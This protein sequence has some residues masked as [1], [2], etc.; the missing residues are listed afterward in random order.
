[1]SQ[2]RKHVSLML[3]VVAALGLDAA[4]VVHGQQRVDPVVSKS[5]VALKQAFADAARAR[6]D[7]RQ[8]VTRAE[9]YADRAR[10][11]ASGQAREV[12]DAARQLGVGLHEFYFHP[13]SVDNDADTQ[14]LLELKTCGF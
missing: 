12:A 10:A 11:D 7:L 9:E 4:S 13:R 6:S 8:A 5:A 14:C 1:M 2:N 3:A